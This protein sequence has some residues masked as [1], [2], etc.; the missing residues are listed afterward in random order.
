MSISR[1]RLAILL[2]VFIGIV[3]FFSLKKTNQF[4]PFPINK[5]KITT[6]FYPLAFLAERIGGSYVTVTNLTPAGAEP[7]DFEPTTR[8]IAELTKQD[9]IFLNGGGIEGYLK[10]LQKN[11]NPKKTSLIVVGQPFMSDQKDPHIWLDP[12]LYI[13]EAEIVAQSLIKRDPLHTKIYTENMKNLI[14]ELSKLDS[15]FQTGLHNCSQKNIITS[16]KAFGYLANR[17]NLH[18][19]AITGL[20]P[21]DEPSSKTLSDIATFAKENNIKY[22]FCEELVSPTIAETIA[23]EVGAKTLV[24]N[25]LEGLTKKDEIAKQTYITIQK[26]NL[27][28]LQIALNCK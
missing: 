22:I 6:S 16:H 9:I 1:I 15:N 4:V 14:N 2:V 3:G 5:L 19:V 10:N 18:E 24:F 12:I 28:N 20:S 21:Q 11:I 25:P 26:E 23:R 27:E 7:H 13:K 17:Y 8:D